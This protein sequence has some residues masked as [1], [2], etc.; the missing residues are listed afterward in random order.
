MKSSKHS[1]LTYYGILLAQFQLIGEMVQLLHK[2]FVVGGEG[3][4]GDVKAFLSPV[5]DCGGIELVA[6]ILGGDDDT[7][8]LGSG[9]PAELHSCDTGNSILKI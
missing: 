4:I 1:D 8:L 7:R 6:L 3:Q 5:L 9:V 2:D